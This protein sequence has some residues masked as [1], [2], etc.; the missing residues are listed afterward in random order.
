MYRTSQETI[1][2][3]FFLTWCAIVAPAINQNNID[4]KTAKPMFDV[5][6]VGSEKPNANNSVTLPLNTSATIKNIPAIRAD[7]TPPIRGRFHCANLLGVG[8]SVMGYSF[9]YFR[10]G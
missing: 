6:R 5:K 8:D 3:T 10:Q 2:N 9:P 7:S 4:K 1:A